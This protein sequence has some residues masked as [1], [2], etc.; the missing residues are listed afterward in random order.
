MGEFVEENEV[1]VEYSYVG[2]LPG[3][4]EFEW[5]RASSSVQGNENLVSLCRSRLVLCVFFRI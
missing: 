4:I 2:G 5:L 3:E 1:S